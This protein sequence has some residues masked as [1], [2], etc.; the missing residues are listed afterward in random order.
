MLVDENNPGFK[1]IS[2]DMADNNM[3]MPLYLCDKKL[4]NNC[5]YP[6][7]KFTT[8]IFNKK[9]VNCKYLEED[10]IDSLS[11]LSDEIMNLDDVDENLRDGIAEAMLN[12]RNALI[13]YI[14]F[15]DKWVKE[16]EE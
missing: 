14:H 9:Q 7:C 6:Q 13:Y 10:L 12:A 16:V 5:S 15:H 8:N 1:E 11:D 3:P 2:K 4:C